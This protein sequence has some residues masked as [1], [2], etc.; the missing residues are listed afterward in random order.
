MYEF[1]VHSNVFLTSIN[2]IY[3]ISRSP[4]F[5]L[6][7]SWN[8]TFRPSVLHGRN[9]SLLSSCSVGFKTLLDPVKNR[10]NVG[11]FP[12]FWE[13][14]SDFFPAD[15]Y[16]RAASSDAFSQRKKRAPYWRNAFCLTF[17]CLSVLQE[18][19]DQKAKK[20]KPKNEKVC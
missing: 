14:I 18:K 9:F 12:F 5:K 17:S 3:T 13:K 20:G 7:F 6:K 8:S 1:F 15:P 10:T 4:N 16:T 11:V 2:V 19:W